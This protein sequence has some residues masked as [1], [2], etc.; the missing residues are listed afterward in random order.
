MKIL[1]AEDD[2]LSRTLL[3]SVLNRIGH[4]VVVTVNGVDALNKLQEAN[5]PKL[6]IIDWMMPILDGLEVLCRIRAMCMNKNGDAY[7]HELYATR[8][9][10]IMLTTKGDK[11]DIIA[12]LDAGADDYLTKPFDMGELKARV[13]VGQRLL[14]MQSALSA[15][16]AELQ[17]A[18]NHINTLR[19]I[20]PI[21]AG[22]KKIRDDAGYWQQVE[23]Y[24]SKYTQAQFSHGICP[25][26]MKRLY[27]EVCDDI[28]DELLM[29]IDYNSG[30][31]SIEEKPDK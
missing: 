26:C 8:P 6:A 25:D 30:G 24:I 16:V 4:E 31:E 15:K 14:E 29:N 23:S 9:Y 20:V 10:I 28:N 11:A 2:L 5:A 1:I 21:C 18:L 12:G 7:E 19:G 17:D 27:P 3:A 22:C 13:D